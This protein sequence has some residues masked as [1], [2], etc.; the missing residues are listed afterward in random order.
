[1][2]KQSYFKQLSL[3]SVHN[4]KIKNSSIS[5]ISV[6]H[7]YAVQMSKQSYFKQFNLALIHSLVLFGISTI[8][9]YLYQIHFYTY[10]Q[11]YFKQFSLVLV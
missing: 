4:F 10:K 3:A 11:F 1:M 5:N 7:K 9:G 8:V 2:S 6:Q